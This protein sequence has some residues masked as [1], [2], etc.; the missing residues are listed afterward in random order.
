MSGDH[1]TGCQLPLGDDLPYTPPLD[2]E[3]CAELLAACSH[4][5]Y[6][7]AAILID[8]AWKDRK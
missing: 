8:P 1:G 3:R 2:D 4:L 5:P 7:I 6:D